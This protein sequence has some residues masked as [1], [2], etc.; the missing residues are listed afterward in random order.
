MRQVK[1]VIQ[2]IPGEDNDYY[3]DDDLLNIQAWGADLSF[4]ELISRYQE[5][6]LLKPELQRRYVWDRSEASRFID[7]LLLGIP[8]P[9]IFLAKTAAETMLIVDGYQRIMTVN[10]FVKGVFGGDNRVFGLSRTEKINPRWAGKTFAE[11]SDT[12][13][14]QGKP[15]SPALNKA[16][17]SQE[18]DLPLPMASPFEEEDWQLPASGE[19]RDILSDMDDAK[20]KGKRKT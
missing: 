20:A 17:D 11:L 13:D 15:T 18:E 3:A 12:P 19:L 2:H 14:F 8:I 16:A 6:T 9:S 7:S 10:D 5:G 1:D 4:R